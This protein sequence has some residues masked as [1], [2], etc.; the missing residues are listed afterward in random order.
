MK[1]RCACNA[2]QVELARRPDFINQCDCSV[3]LRFG[4]AWG[5]FH[6]DDVTIAGETAQ[7]VRNDV[8]D[9]YIAYHSCPACGSTTHW[10]P[11]PNGPSERRGVNMRLFEPD[12]LEGLEV[13][14]TDGLRRQG[15][16]RPPDRHEPITIRN[17]WPT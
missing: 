4:A 13:R 2:V 3:C 6:S 10:T 8:P 17:R 12:D 9:P 1:G 7:F 15:K 11:L 5:Y 16:A 14:F